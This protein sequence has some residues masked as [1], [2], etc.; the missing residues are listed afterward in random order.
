[1]QKKQHPG[2]SGAASGGVPQFAPLPGASSLERDGR[3]ILAA[4]P[5][6]GPGCPAP[7]DSRASRGI[8]FL[9]C[10]HM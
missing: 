10:R 4:V 9:G 7:V 3:G 6:R 8:G 1:M 5:T 2:L